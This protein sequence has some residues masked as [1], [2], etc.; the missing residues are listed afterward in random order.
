LSLDA[1]DP[2]PGFA[3][4]SRSR[5]GR[6]AGIDFAFWQKAKSSAGLYFLS[7]EKE[8]M[9]LMVSG[10]RPFDRTDPRNA[11]VVA[12][13]LVSPAS[14][15]AMLR[16]IVY[17][18]PA[19]GVEYRYLTAETTLPPGLIVLLYNGSSVDGRLPGRSQG[20]L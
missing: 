15:G 12:D 16:R 11:G 4:G 19:E 1:R 3:S 10:N 17:I 8:N 7:R 9:N 18:D 14:G 6:W 2:R 20:I 5:A 13:E